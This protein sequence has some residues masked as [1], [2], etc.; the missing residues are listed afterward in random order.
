MGHM[1]R[2]QNKRQPDSHLM[3]LVHIFFAKLIG[4]CWELVLFWGIVHSRVS[5]RVGGCAVHILSSFLLPRH[6]PPWSKKTLPRA[7]LIFRTDSEFNFSLKYF[8]KMSP[9]WTRRCHRRSS[10]SRWRS[11]WLCCR[12]CSSPWGRNVTVIRKKN[13]KDI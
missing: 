9:Q 4:N 2:K 5:A 12:R 10:L 1:I 6:A 8:S 11:N 7:S 3:Q 13:L